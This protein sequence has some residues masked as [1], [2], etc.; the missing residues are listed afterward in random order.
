MTHPTLIHAPG[1]AADLRQR[2]VLLFTMLVFAGMMLVIVA[3]V[4]WMAPNY[5]P[6]RVAGFCMFFG[7]LALLLNYTFWR[8]KK[9]A[10][11]QAIIE[12]LE[13]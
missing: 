10:E 2:S 8:T 4:P 3:S 11:V 5:I 13:S 12:R 9:R 6:E 7:T 1:S